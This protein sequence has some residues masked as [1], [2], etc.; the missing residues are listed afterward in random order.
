MALTIIAHRGAS[1]DAPE[2]TLPAFAMAW[3]QQADGIELDVHLTADGRLVVIHDHDTLRV[4][5][6]KRPVVEA[7][8]TELQALDAGRWKGEAWR[9][10][11]LAELG[12][13]LA[14]QPADKRIV[15]E[16]KGKPDLVPAVCE[17]LQQARLPPAQ[18]EVISFDVETMAAAARA[19][20][21]HRCY[22]LAGSW[23]AAEGRR[24]LDLPG[25]QQ[26]VSTARLAGLDLEYRTVLE[27]PDC[28]AAI[29]A[30]GLALYVWTVDDVE[31]ARRLVALGVDGITTNRPAAIRD[32]LAAV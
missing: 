11:K 22:L 26:T 25:L 9:G 17:A 16:L 2:N 19:L 28:V 14:V 8:L 23:R 7:T 18:V 4:T 27:N 12:Q 32:G 29:R 30:A 5:G 21:E 1:A 20:P 3:E 10:T 13:V 6:I 31:A 15:I 24:A